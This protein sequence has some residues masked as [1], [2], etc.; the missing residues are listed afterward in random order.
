MGLFDGNDGLELL[1]KATKFERGNVCKNLGLDKGKDNGSTP[2]V[3][4]INAMKY[5]LRAGMRR[6]QWQTGRG[7]LVGNRGIK[8]RENAHNCKG[9]TLT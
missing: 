2:G 4:L 7:M 8:R 5:D 1:G 3:N 6:G 9:S